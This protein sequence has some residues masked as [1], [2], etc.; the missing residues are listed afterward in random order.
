MSGRAATPGIPRF[1]GRPRSP[2]WGNPESVPQTTSPC[3]DPP[4]THP[5]RPDA[6]SI[7]AG[8]ARSSTSRNHES[9][10]W[11]VELNQH[12]ADLRRAQRGV[13]QIL[14]KLV[15]RPLEV[16]IVLPQRVVGVDD[17]VLT[18]HF[19]PLGAKR[20]GISI[21]ASTSTGWG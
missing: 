4:R 19:A 17:Q 1:P 3:P 16:D 5:V 6:G 20:N 8:C 9:S 13:I 21:N 15:E 12:I 18:G 2:P 14:H 7:A 11:P 10:R